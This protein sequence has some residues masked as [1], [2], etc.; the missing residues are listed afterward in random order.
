METCVDVHDMPVVAE[1]AEGVRTGSLV[2]LIRVLVMRAL[3]QDKMNPGQDA[4]AEAALPATTQVYTPPRQPGYQPAY[5]GPNTQP[6]G[7]T[8]A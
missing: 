2:A 8:K 4:A 1:S 5:I 6:A 7:A 3:R